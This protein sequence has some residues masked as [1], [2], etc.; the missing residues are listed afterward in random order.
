MN[1]F[2]YGL[3]GVIL[4]GISYVFKSTPKVQ[5]VFI[6]LGGSVMFYATILGIQD[7]MNNKSQSRDWTEQDK[8]VIIKDCK[9]NKEHNA[10]PEQVDE[11]CNCLA[12]SIMNKFGVDEYIELDNLPDKERLNILTPLA[13]ECS[14]QYFKQGSNIIIQGDSIINLPAE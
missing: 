10:A 1:D 8:Q 7:I 11:W 3:I 6:V 2:I 13:S 14:K 12:E 5:L 4:L 9:N